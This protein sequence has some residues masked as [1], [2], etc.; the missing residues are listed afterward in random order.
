M[1]V[2]KKVA[3]FTNEYPPH[4]YGGAGVHVEYLARAMA[5]LLS[6]EVRCFGDEE[7][8]GRQPRRA[9]LPAL[10]GSQTRHRP[11][12]RLRRR[13]LRSLARDGQGHARCGRGPLPHL[14]HRHGRP[15]GEPALGRTLRTDHPFPRA[16]ASL[17]GGAARQR[18]PPEH[19]DGTD[20]NGARQCYRRRLQTDPRGRAAP[21]RRSSRRG[22]MSSTTAST[23]RS[24][25]GP[26]TRTRSLPT[27]SAL[28]RTISARQTCLCGALRSPATVVRRRRSTSL[29]VMEIPVRMRQTCMQRARRES[30]PGFKC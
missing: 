18:L 20:R 24:T 4:V 7:E 1:P 27:P 16:A 15:S 30:L 21:V 10:G 9:W 5:K 6:V 22:C 13:C 17:E 19:L 23:R 25:A 8:R 28:N 2:L 3:L 29:R 26:R 12:V 11:A 14:V